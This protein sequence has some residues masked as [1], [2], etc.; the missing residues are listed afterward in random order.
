M[1]V[2][3][4]LLAV[5]VTQVVRVILVIMVLLDQQARKVVEVILDHKVVLA[6]KDRRD[7][8]ATQV[9]KVFLE[10]MVLQYA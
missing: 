7:V 6:H 2:Q 8:K 3:P 1:Q 4:V 10:P 9:A 5:W